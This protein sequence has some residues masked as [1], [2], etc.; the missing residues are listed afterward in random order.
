MSKPFIRGPFEKFV[1][2]QQCTTVMWRR[3]VTII[4]GIKIMTLLVTPIT[5]TWHKSLPPSA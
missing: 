5:T 2:W 3:A 4:R 1:D